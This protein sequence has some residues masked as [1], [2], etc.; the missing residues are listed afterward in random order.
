LKTVRKKSMRILYHHR[1]R[2]TDAQRI[3]ILEVAGALSA[4][5][6]TVELVSLIS[7]ETKISDAKRDAGD[8]FW[9]KIARRLPFAYDFIQLSYNLVGIPLLLW[10]ALWH[11]PEFIYERYSLFNFTGVVAGGLLRVPVVLE[12][13]SP[14][15]LEH[16]RENHT[17]LLKFA[18]WSERVICNMA[19]RV[20]AVSGPLARILE[21]NG[22]DRTKIEIMS[23]GVNPERFRPAPADLELKHSLG[24]S[25]HT[26]IGFVGWFRKWHGIEMLLEAFR[27]AD[28][29]ARAKVL[30]VG[31]GQA[32][33]D[34]Q[35]FVHR[36][37]LHDSVVFSGPL[38]HA[39][40][41][42]YVNLIDIAVQPA[43]N[44]YCCPMKILEYMA[45]GKAIVAP[46]QENIQELLSED[47]E[48]LLFSP[49]S[50]ASLA[51]ALRRLVNG[52]SESARLGSAARKAIETKRLLWSENA[53]RVADLLPS[54]LPAQ[55]Q[56]GAPAVARVRS[57]E[58]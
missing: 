18:S 29:S 46:R 23:N 14:M 39:E 52:P 57:E 51:I 22:I 12:V 13:N 4:L 55:R 1:T 25:D 17:H 20:I 9:K 24:L 28:L 6:H 47:A 34:I 19:G 8:V 48:A 33:S 44:E 53:R 49:G 15:A 21:Q 3:H 35:D 56:A 30:L 36:H 27:L 16:A 58:S 50:A 41:T 26:V 10:R 7:T 32:M 11:R 43:A 37:S 5:G 31:D 2:A 54:S 40:I 38:P 45:L 42:R